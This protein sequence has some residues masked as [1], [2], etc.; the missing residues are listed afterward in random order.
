MSELN[1][2][3]GL[4]VSTRAV[5]GFAALVWLAQLTVP[6][7]LAGQEAAAADSVQDAAL[8]SAQSAVAANT[9]EAL[10]L[11]DDGRPGIFFMLAA[12][13]GQRRDGCILCASPEDVDGFTGH[14]GFGRYLAR[15]LGIGVDASVWRK[16][17]QGPPLPA[18]STG[19]AVASTL[20]NMLG[21]A[22]I[23][24]SYTLWHLYVRAGGG[25]AWGHQDIEETDVAGEITVIRASG[26]GVGYSVG[27]G[28]TLPVYGPVSLA[29]F[30]NWNHGRY[31]LA[32]ERSVLTRDATHSYLELGV[33]LTIR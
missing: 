26:I 30:G 22:S 9:G 27:A 6:A 4:T 7:L 17:R 18:D 32:G 16:T 15:G 11:G 21:N 33:G 10:A 28:A 24:L 13:Y 3:R 8:D 19:V 5:L 20:S 2:K 12:G 31:D 25:V 23:S 29:F 1:P 14:A